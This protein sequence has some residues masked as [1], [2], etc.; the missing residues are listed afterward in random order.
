MQIKVEAGTIDFV[1]IPLPPFL[2]RSVYTF[3]L[4]VQSPSYLFICVRSLFQSLAALPASC[5]FRRRKRKKRVKFYSGT[6][7][8]L[9][10]SESHNTHLLN[11]QRGG[12][13]GIDGREVT[14]RNSCVCPSCLLVTLLYK[15]LL[16]ARSPQN[17]AH[18][19]H[20]G[21]TGANRCGWCNYL[22][23]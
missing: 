12:H 15:N 17:C 8:S 20:C 16:S 9:S 21:W 3:S 1:S 14:T 5:T 11:T 23:C 10:A 7:L 2:K 18:R 6:A 22:R 13:L 4:V 19:P